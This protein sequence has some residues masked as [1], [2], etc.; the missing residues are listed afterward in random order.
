MTNMSDRIRLTKENCTVE[1]VLPAHMQIVADVL[2]ALGEL[3]FTIPDAVGAKSIEVQ[4][5]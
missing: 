4:Y 2:V 5:A 1:V 3:G